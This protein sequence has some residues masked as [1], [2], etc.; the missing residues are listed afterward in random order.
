MVLQCC[1]DMSQLIE[2]NYVER[3]GI[4]IVRQLKFSSSSVISI[5]GGKINRLMGSLNIAMIRG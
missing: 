5:V 1:L 3:L 2:K 4:E